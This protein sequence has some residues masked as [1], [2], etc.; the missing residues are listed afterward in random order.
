MRRFSRLASR[1]DIW[2]DCGSEGLSIGCQIALGPYISSS[3]VIAVDINKQIGR[4]VAMIY[5]D[6]RGAITYRHV[7]IRSIDNGKAQVYD[8]GKHAPRTLQLDGI[9]DWRPA[10]ERGLS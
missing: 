7:S 3:V 4:V 2:S 8:H 6:Q 10:R 5:V 1:T 9:L